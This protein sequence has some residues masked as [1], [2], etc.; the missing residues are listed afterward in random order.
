MCEMVEFASWYRTQTRAPSH[1]NLCVTVDDKMTQPTC[2]SVVAPGLPEG[3]TSLAK[4][5]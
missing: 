4:E 2:I 5:L 1:C 3:D